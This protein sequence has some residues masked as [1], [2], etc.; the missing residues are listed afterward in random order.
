MTRSSVT[1]SIAKTD[2]SH[3]LGH[4][5][6]IDNGNINAMKGLPA[7]AVPVGYSPVSQERNH[8]PT[9]PRINAVG[10]LLIALHT[11]SIE[12]FV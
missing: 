2:A 4:H 8:E 5:N 12:P 1:C 6:R 9:S 11:S 7:L 10:C 3:N